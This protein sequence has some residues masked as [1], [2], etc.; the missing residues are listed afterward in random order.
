MA[1]A[2]GTATATATATASGAV[3]NLPAEAGTA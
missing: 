1:V 2:A 3:T